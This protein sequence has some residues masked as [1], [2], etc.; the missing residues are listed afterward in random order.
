MKIK[1]KTSYFFTLVELLIVIA[2]IAILAALLMPSL[3]R[4]KEVS[5]KMECAQR[6]K[7]LGLATNN[8]IQDYENWFPGASTCTSHGDYMREI[9]LG[10]YVGNNENN[11][12]KEQ[13]KVFFCPS[14]RNLAIHKFNAQLYISSGI[15][16]NASLT[17]YGTN[18]QKLQNIKTSP[19]IWGMFVDGM[20][21]RWVGWG[22]Y[23]YYYDDA[24]NWLDTWNG[25]A[26][27]SFYNY[28]PR[29]LKQ[30]NVLFLDNHVNSFNNLNNAFL[31]G[32]LNYE[33]K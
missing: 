7:Q 33:W 26:T 10:Q 4:A 20:G 11:W 12:Y 31:A 21:N 25:S 23:P 5:K 16:I 32:D 22:N 18:P 19:S 30:C 17:D 6:M 27:G 14:A 13:S 2:I 9:M 8:Y 1:F 3:S 28:S 15:A 24:P 29:H